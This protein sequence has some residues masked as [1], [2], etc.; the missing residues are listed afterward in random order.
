M[1]VFV[2]NEMNNPAQLECSVCFEGFAQVAHRRP[3]L[4]HCG[5]CFCS[6]CVS[7]LAT[8]ESGIE[9]PS[10]HNM[11]PIPAK[12]V[13]GNLVYISLLCLTFFW[14][15]KNFFVLIFPP[16]NVVDL[17]VNFALLDLLQEPAQE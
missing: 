6:S 16:F 5:H 3:L 15:D 10:C 2:L 7:V 9:C 14:K 13:S 4:L 12:G 11:T 8:N 1:A 17:P